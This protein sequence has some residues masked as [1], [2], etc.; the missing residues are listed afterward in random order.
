MNYTFDYSRKALEDLGFIVET[1][2]NWGPNKKN[3]VNKH[4]FLTCS[5]LLFFCSILFQIFNT[6]IVFICNFFYFILFFKRSYHYHYYFNSYFYFFC[7][8]LQ[9]TYGTLNLMWEMRVMMPES[10]TIGKK[11]KIQNY[12]V[13]IRLIFSFYYCIV[14]LF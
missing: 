12:N 7:P 13:K 5:A 10:V 9:C 2:G 3:K 6:L 11:N 4:F 8:Y 14:L 1:D